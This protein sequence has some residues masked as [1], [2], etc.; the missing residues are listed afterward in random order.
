MRAIEL[1]RRQIDHTVKYLLFVQSVN[2]VLE[3]S[4]ELEDFMNERQWG[5]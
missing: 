4:I 2:R 1:I 5:E 3:E